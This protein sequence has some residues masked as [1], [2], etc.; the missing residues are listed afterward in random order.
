M[1]Y[2]TTVKV[3]VEEFPT[4]W[5]ACAI[6]CLYDRDRLSRDDHLGMDVTNSY[7]EATFRFSDTEFLDFDDRVA[8]PLPELYA[9]VYDSAG[10]CVMSTRAIAE[11]NMIPPL[12]RIPIPQELA[13]KHGLI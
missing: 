12:I 10:N 2:H 6:V 5:I 3:F 4:D 1:D 9:R 11:R 7:G 13:R 8:G